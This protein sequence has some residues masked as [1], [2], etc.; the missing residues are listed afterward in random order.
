MG[1][2]LTD[3]GAFRRAVQLEQSI[4]EPDAEILPQNRFVRVVTKDGTTATGRLLNQDAFT[5]QLFDPKERM[6][7]FQRTNIKEVTFID[8]SPMP[9]YK[10]KLSTQELADVVSYLT[11]LKGIEAK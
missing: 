6:M 4:L 9:S 2:E 11:S 1:P 7:T 10:G 3:I 5:L 8:K